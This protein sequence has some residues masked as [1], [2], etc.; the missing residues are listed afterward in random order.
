MTD[1]KFINIHTHSDCGGLEVCIVNLLANKPAPDK[2]KDS[3][4]YSIGLHP[5]HIT[6]ESLQIYKR[7]IR[8]SLVHPNIIAIG[9]TGID[10]TLKIPLDQQIAVFKSHVII[11]EEF[12]LPV[13]LP[14]F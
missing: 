9:E 1:S 2:L 12:G 10:R 7:T 11:S 13:I 14:D 3:G 8:E 6:E 4:Y 5:W